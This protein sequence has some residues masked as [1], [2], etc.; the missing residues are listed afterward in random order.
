M[1]SKLL[2]FL[3]SHRSISLN[4]RNRHDRP[5]HLSNPDTPVDL[6]CKEKIF[7]SRVQIFTNSQLN[8]PGKPGGPIRPS[9]HQTADRENGIKKVYL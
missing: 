3:Q 9:R 2:K 8:V 5:Y 6:V 7:M 4:L 1:Q